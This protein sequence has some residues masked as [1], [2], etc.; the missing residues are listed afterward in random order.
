MDKGQLFV[1]STKQAL[2]MTEGTISP[3]T[4]TETPIF[5]DLMS[6]CSV[7][8]LSY[9]SGRKS[10]EIVLPRQTGRAEAFF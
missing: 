6:V 5:M 2:F 1:L 9:F 3:F 4:F 10:M 8:K 7:H